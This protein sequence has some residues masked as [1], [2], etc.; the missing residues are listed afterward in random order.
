MK[1]C[2]KRSFSSGVEDSVVSVVKS[3]YRHV[4]GCCVNRNTRRLKQVNREN[5]KYQGR[6]GMSETVKHRTKYK[7]KKT[8]VVQYCSSRRRRM[9]HTETQRILEKL[10]EKLEL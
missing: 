7:G 3:V 4:C 6:E 5:Y 9:R 10:C 2:G 8:L 1:C